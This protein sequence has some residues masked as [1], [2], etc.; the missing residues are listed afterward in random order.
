LFHKANNYIILKIKTCKQNTQKKT[1]NGSCVRGTELLET[2]ILKE[3]NGGLRQPFL[4]SLPSSWPP[5]Q[6]QLVGKRS[7]A[8]TPITMTLTIFNCSSAPLGSFLFLKQIY[9]SILYVQ[10]GLFLRVIM[11]VPLTDLSHNVDLQHQYGIHND[12]VFLRE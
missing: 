7:E 10:R 4:A 8:P 12:E 1:E 5:C 2:V 9:K 11:Q 3:G 6:R